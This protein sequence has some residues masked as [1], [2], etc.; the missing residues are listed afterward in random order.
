MSTAVS[1]PENKSMTVEEF[2]ELPDDGTERWLLRGELRPKDRRTTVRNRH[3]SEIE[4]T[5]AFLLKGWLEPQPEPKGKIHSGEPAFRLGRDPDTLFG[6]D[7][8]YASAELVG[9]TDPESPYYDGPPVLAVEILSPSDKHEDIVRKITAYLHAGVIVWEV[10]PDFRRVSVHRTG[11]AS[12]T[13][14]AN[15]ELTTEP[16]LPGFRVLVAEFFGA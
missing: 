6:I 8:A 16:E 2:L 4:A 12:K 1:P 13:F 11:Q 5:I 7:V 3:P 10:D 9:N 14:Y 15:D